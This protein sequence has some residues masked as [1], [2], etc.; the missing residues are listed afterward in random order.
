MI[1]II[2]FPTYLGQIFACAT[3][4]C[5]ERTPHAIFALALV[6]SHVITNGLEF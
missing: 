4:E 1:E 2:T 6:Q 3:L 5:E